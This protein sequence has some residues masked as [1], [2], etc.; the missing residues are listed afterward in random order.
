M[1]VPVKRNMNPERKPIGK[2]RNAINA[3]IVVNGIAV[4]H[5]NS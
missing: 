4:D 3:S 5:C 2:A 1:V